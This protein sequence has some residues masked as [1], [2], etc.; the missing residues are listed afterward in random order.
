[1]LARMNYASTLAANQKF[2]LATAA[3][4]ASANPQTFLSYYLDQLA[5]APFDDAIVDEFSRYLQAT[6]AWTGSAA[7]LQ[8]K[9][10]GLVRLIL[11][12]PE[13]QLI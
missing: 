9:A 5:T 7:Q 3:T 12:S 11:G 13:Y 1:M 6:G 8:A 4:S 10:P 2:N